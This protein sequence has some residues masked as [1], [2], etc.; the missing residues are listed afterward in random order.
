MSSVTY[1]LN[2]GY[3]QCLVSES[4][5]KGVEWNILNFLY[6]LYI[7]LFPPVTYIRTILKFR[8]TRGHTGFT[9]V[10]ISGKKKA[11]NAF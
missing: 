7:G 4:G 8:Q 11:C 2:Y 9:L 3:Q 5:L 6:R 1:R 10:M